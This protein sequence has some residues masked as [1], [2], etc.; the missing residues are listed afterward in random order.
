LDNQ[1]GLLSKGGWFPVSYEKFDQFLS[2]AERV[3]NRIIL[4]VS[5]LSGA[6]TVLYFIYK[7]FMAVFGKPG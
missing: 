6:I 2:T 4:F 1:Q 3:I 5:T 7:G